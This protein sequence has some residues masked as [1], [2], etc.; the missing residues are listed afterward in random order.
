MRSIKDEYALSIMIEFRLS[1]AAQ[2][3]GPTAGRRLK[4]IL[5]MAINLQVTIGRQYFERYLRLSSH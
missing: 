4:F 1:D 3:P 2:K 5:Y